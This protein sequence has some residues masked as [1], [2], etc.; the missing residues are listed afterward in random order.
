MKEP[1]LKIQVGPN[2]G[3]HL[4][5]DLSDVRTNVLGLDKIDLTS[6][7]T[8][9]SALATIDNAVQLVSQERSKYGAYMNALEHLSQ[10]VSNAYENLVKA[11]SQLRDADMA[12]EMSKLQKDQV[13]LQSSQSMMAQ[14]NQMSQ[15]ILEVLK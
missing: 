9:D 3:Q 2:E 5:I 8:A 6:A 12:K 7:Q 15:G 11:E 13:L 1:D 14:I 10:N 4:L